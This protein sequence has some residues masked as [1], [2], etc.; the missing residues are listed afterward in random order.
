MPDGLTISQLP[1]GEKSILPD[2]NSSL[3]ALDGRL[4]LLFSK[5]VRPEATSTRRSVPRRS[6]QATTR[7]SGDSSSVPQTNIGSS[8]DCTRL[9]SEMLQR[10]TWAAD[11]AS[12]IRS[13][14]MRVPPATNTTCRESGVNFAVPAS[15][16]GMRSRRGKGCTVI[17]VISK[18]SWASTYRPS[19]LNRSLR[20]DPG[21][22]GRSSAMQVPKQ[23]IKPMAEAARREFTDVILLPA[24]FSLL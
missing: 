18:S 21:G 9:R 12:E 20:K 16:A 15:P 6:M 5:T 4:N 10:S 8:V 24:R 19:G 14:S 7:P 11:F 22:A 23:K 1:S 13:G 17:N 3:D 2:P